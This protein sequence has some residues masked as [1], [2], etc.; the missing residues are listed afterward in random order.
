MTNRRSFLTSLGALSGLALLSKAKRLE[1]MPSRI[2]SA[3]SPWDLTWLD[4]FNGTHRQLFDFGR[5]DISEESHLEVVRNWLNAHKEVYGL[6]FPQVDTIVGI[7]ARAYPLNA[8]DV[9]WQKYPIGEMWKIKDPK[10]SAW[11][12]RNVYR[13]PA[14]SDSKGAY[15]ID[16]LVA[17]GTAFWQCNNALGYVVGKLAKAVGKP[18][19]A[20]RAELLAG[21][22]P[23]VHLVP[24][25]T[26][27]VGLA[28]EHRFAYE[29]M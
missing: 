14:E 20:V 4:K 3:A 12:E 8:S 5:V 16:A 27:L 26:M 11:A 1:A 15:S 28:Q 29:S 10:T 22:M 25:H 24:A 23:G 17:R 9:L 7:A 21:M 13:D 19:D 18:T 2:T 6:E